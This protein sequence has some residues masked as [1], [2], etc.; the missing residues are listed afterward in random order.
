MR[1]SLRG[2]ALADHPRVGEIRGRGLMAGVEFVIDRE[3]REPFPRAARLA[4]SIVR[5]A[6]AAGRL[7]HTGT[8][9]GDGGDGDIVLLGPPVVGTDGELVRIADGRADALA[10]ALEGPVAEVLAA[11]R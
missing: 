10:M 5:M 9:G 4:E 7:H 11:H 2:G 8:G 1:R 6:R 3:T